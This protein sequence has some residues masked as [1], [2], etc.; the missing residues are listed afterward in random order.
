[1]RFAPASGLLCVPLS[2]SGEQ[3]LGH[4]LLEY[5][6]GKV[7]DQIKVVAVAKVGAG[8][9]CGPGSAVGCFKKKS[10]IVTFN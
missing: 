9:C 10:G 5:L 1:M 6:D 4:L 7:P 8:L 3:T 2:I